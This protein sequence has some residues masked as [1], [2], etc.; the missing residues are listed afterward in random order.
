MTLI[1]LIPFHGAMP[2]NPML[3]EQHPG[4]ELESKETE[5][6]AAFSQGF[7]GVQSGV[8]LESLMSAE[9]LD[10]HL[11]G[12]ADLFGNNEEQRGFSQIIR[13]ARS[14]VSP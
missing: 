4:L 7:T 9:V 12:N 10:A 5:I 14:C 8:F 1:I 2:A 13:A 3:C 6:G 11:M